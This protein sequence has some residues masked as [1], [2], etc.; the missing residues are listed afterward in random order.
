MCDVHQLG[1]RAGLVR[2]TS[3]DAV[4][5]LRWVAF[6]RVKVVALLCVECHDVK[7]LSIICLTKSMEAT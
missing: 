5:W 4:G 6:R 1:D 3:V 2:L 7:R